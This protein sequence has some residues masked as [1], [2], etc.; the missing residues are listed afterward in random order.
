MPLQGVERVI[1]L[2]VTESTVCINTQRGGGNI[3]VAKLSEKLEN[4]A[5]PC[6]AARE[7]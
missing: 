4:G 3:D 2:D 5:E 7:V 1:Y 6:A